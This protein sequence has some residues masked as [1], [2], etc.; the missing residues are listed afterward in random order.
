[1]LKIFS[2]KNK[3][4]QEIPQ[5]DLLQQGS[6]SEDRD[7]EYPE[8]VDNMINDGVTFNR[9]HFII[10]T[11][12]GNLKYA[13]SFFVKPSGYPRTVRIGWLEN[14]F[15]GDDVDVSVHI[16]PLDR[17]AAIKKLQDKIDE[18]AVVMYSAQKRGDQAKYDD[19]FQKQDDTKIIQREIKNN[20]NGL[21][22]VSIQATVYANSLDELNGKCVEIENI[23][24][25]ESIEIL[26]AY[27]R[28]RDGFLSCLP[29]G[30][31]HLAK[32][33]RNLDQRSL[34][35]IFPHASSK[36][37]HQAGF[38]IGRSGRDYVY[39][40]NFDNS[41]NNYSVG[42]FGASGSGKSVLV[43]QFI[44]RG[45][46][47]GIT[48]NVI[49]DV[50]PEY[51]ELTKALGGVVIPIYP[52][53]SDFASRIN[54]LDIYPEKELMNKGKPDEYV[55]EK[56]NLNE[57]VKEAIEFFKIMKQSVKGFDA[58]LGAIE[59]GVL[60]DIM[61][62]AYRSR[63]ITEDPDTI[64][65]QVQSIDDFGS[66]TYERK[67]IL[68]PTISEIH[69]KVK[70]YWQNGYEE[71]KELMT[72]IELF[73]AGRAFGMFDGQ[74]NII[75]EGN[76]VS[77]DDAPVVTFDI[78]RLSQNGIER[79]LAMHVITT[80]VWSRF[81]TSNPKAKKRVLIDEAWQQIPYKSM[82]SWLKVLSLRGRK[83][84]TS[85]TL[86]SQRYEMFDRDETARDVVSQ[87][88]T[89]CF[90]RQADQ[91]IDPI[92][93]TFRLSRDVGEMIRTFST[94]EVLM[95]ANKQIVH[96]HSEPT[97]EEWV[98]LNTNQNVQ[99]GRVRPQE[100]EGAAS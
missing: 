58:N 23:V 43:K 76:N 68:M 98:Y 46:S 88:D 30:K 5:S 7:F 100:K 37:N 42:I 20:Q 85:L 92:L 71:L 67:Y 53:N 36:L 28:Q 27:G 10:Q 47:D 93:K 49:I 83:W 65:E 24:G 84:N 9:D 25:G 64:F 57:K 82:M 59:L 13:R 55:V 39:Y 95:K 90:L 33:D 12:L 15:S 17:N 21:F 87:F 45:F 75:S 14:L 35:A 41:L 11:G 19:A 22:Y 99:M 62:A 70:E 94:G 60:N 79:P 96:F 1:M 31:N 50:E 69:G 61:T 32:S 77:L 63:G 81:I 29:L 73:T 80:W 8:L 86:V 18:L 91:D 51:V 34:T 26:N 74:T 6:K 54:P 97:P 66:I 78:S 72:I 38:P 44:G 4:N 52:T 2:K 16:D 56:V 3:K 89:I 48:K 40:N